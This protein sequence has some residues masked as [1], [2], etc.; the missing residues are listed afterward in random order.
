MSGIE[1]HTK[2]EFVGVGLGPGDPELVTLKAIVA[3]QQ[4]DVVAYLT[5]DTGHSRALTIAQAAV[6][7]MSELVTTDESMLKSAES[8][9]WPMAAQT[10]PLNMPM[11][12]D[13]TAANR[14]Y[15][16]AAQSIQ[17]HMDCGKRVV[18]LCEGD[19]LFFGSFAYLLER[20]Q[21]SVPCRVIPGITSIA[22]ASSTLSLPLTRLTESLAV[23]SG[24]HDD[25]QIQAALTEYD[26]VAILK[27][28]RHRP[29]LLTLLKKT[30]RLNE[31]VYLENMGMATQR[32]ETDCLNL[33]QTQAAELGP[34]FSL[35][36]VT[37]STFMNEPRT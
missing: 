20:L 26:S 18:F 35:F 36:I 1:T 6:A 8:V 9:T 3:M 14:V 21:Q 25:V 29:R 23:V 34:Y 17:H 7:R 4:A 11:R 10:L 24:R 12:L 19:P 32:V 5:N 15:D 27:A 33:Y 37:R 30:G 28:G 22:A 16:E 13:R 2:T 31:A